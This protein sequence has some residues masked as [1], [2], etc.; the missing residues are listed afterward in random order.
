MRRN[1]K[2]ALIA[3]LILFGVIGVVAIFAIFVSRV[4]RRKRTE[5]FE[6][7]AAELGLEFAPEVGESYIAGLD[8]FELFSK[9]RSK[10][11]SNLLHGT[12]HDRS[13]AIFDYRYTIGRG[14]QTRT[15]HTTVM[16]VQ[17]DG[18]ALP[19][20]WLRAES[21]WDKI[22]SKFG[23]HDIDFDTHPQF[24]RKY[25]LRGDNEVAVRAVFTPT[26]LEYFEA[27]PGLN[28]EAWGQS[29]LFYRLGKHVKPD[30]VNDFLADGLSLLGLF[31][32]A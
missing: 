6:Q 1:D 19:H 8:H 15:L 12:S 5:A 3:N 22:A 30:E 31:N 13:L 27:H 26:V 24:S 16:Q 21:V 11:V 20:F 17:F 7:I 23:S 25:L 14:K 29:L 28:I 2:N 4:R 9:G 18:P 10:K 32:R